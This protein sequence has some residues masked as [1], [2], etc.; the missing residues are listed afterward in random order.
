MFFINSTRP[1]PRKNMSKR[2]RFADSVEWVTYSLFEKTIEA[3]ERSLIE[4]LPMAIVLP[5]QGSEDQ[6][7]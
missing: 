1:T 4:G 2:L 7:H 3:F 5:A 6:T